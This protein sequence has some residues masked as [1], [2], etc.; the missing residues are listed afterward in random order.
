MY[1]LGH[2]GVGTFI[3]EPISRRLPWK[4]IAF[5]TLLPDLIDKPLYY[6][7]AWFNGVHGPANG[8]ISGTRTFGHSLL[9]LLLIFLAGRFAAPAAQARK[10][11]P[12]TTAIAVGMLT[13]LLLD[14]AMD[15]VLDLL[16]QTFQDDK[17]PPLM[18]AIFFPALGFEFP[19]FRWKDM[20]GHLSVFDRWPAI[21]AEVLGAVLIWRKYSQSSLKKSKAGP[22]KRGPGSA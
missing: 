20:A 11:E 2:I 17:S 13:H 14:F 1:P 3:A 6:G 8:L 16:L 19:Y 22:Q 12:I 21:V 4:W 5:G 18:N 15:L 10:I 7:T 9:V